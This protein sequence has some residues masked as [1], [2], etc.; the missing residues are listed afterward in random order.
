MIFWEW[1]AH[2][3]VALGQVEFYVS[4]NNVTIQSTA[5]P[6]KP[7]P[8]VTIAAS[9]PVG[10]LSNVASDYRDVGSSG[11]AGTMI[12]PKVDSGPTVLLE[13]IDVLTRIGV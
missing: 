12:G 3:V 7:E 9:N 2:H 8:L 1:A 13:L 5:G 6:G 10:H 11:R 4:C